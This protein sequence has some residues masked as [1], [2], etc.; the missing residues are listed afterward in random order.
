VIA[1]LSRNSQGIR[2]RPSILAGGIC[3]AE[4]RIDRPDGLSVRRWSIIR[5]LLRLAPLRCSVQSNWA[6][7]IHRIFRV[8]PGF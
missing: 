8:I 3:S 5:F 7:N 4:R 1:E 2:A 6:A